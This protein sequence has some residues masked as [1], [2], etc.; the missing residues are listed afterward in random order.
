MIVSHNYMYINSQEVHVRK[1]LLER[2]AGD[3]K[4]VALIF[5]GEVIEITYSTYM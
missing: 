2:L 4:H 1:I 3:V 5:V